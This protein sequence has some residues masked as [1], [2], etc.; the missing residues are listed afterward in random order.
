MQKVYKTCLEKAVMGVPWQVVP[1]CLIVIS[2]V[3]VTSCNLPLYTP[4]VTL[5]NRLARPSSWSSSVN[6]F[7]PFATPDYVILAWSCHVQDS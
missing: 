7:S 6:L 3:S 2:L 5:V 4:C 1:S